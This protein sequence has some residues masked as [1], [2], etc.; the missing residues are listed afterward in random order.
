MLPLRFRGRSFVNVT[1]LSVRR[2]AVIDVSSRVTAFMLKNS[3]H[4]NLMYC[5]QR[6][7]KTEYKDCE[8]K[9][10]NT[11]FLG[12]FAKQLFRAITGFVLPVRM[13]QFDS[14]WM[15]FREIVYWGFVLKYADK[16]QG[17]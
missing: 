6:L 10:C 17:I 7:K 15:N 8:N 9:L 11:E 16:I 3:F 13:K 12:V 14:H 1:V 5:K 4:I 2:S